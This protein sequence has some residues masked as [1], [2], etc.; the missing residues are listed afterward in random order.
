MEP[1][2]SSFPFHFINQ[3]LLKMLSYIVLELELVD[4]TGLFSITLFLTILMLK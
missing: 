2:N 1:K 3:L 4:A